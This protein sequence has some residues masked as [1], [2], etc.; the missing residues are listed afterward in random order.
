[1]KKKKSFCKNIPPFLAD[2]VFF[3][4]WSDE[5][6]AEVQHLIKFMM[7]VVVNVVV[8]T[9]DEYHEKEMTKKKLDKVKIVNCDICHDRPNPSS[10]T[11]NNGKNKNMRTPLTSIIK[12]QSKYMG[13]DGVRTVET[14]MMVMMMMRG[15][16]R[17]T[18]VFIKRC[19]QL[20]SKELYIDD[21]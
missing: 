21:R 5:E 15:K 2:I 20:C 14:A 18:S 8:V 1:M 7:I 9:V 13:N 19:K 4:E 6:R 17:R 16:N 3:L 12:K 10:S 11:S